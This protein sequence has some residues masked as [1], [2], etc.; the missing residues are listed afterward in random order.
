MRALVLTAHLD[1]SVPL[2]AQKDCTAAEKLVD[3]VNARREPR[4]LFQCVHVGED[5]MGIALLLHEP[6]DDDTRFLVAVAFHEEVPAALQRMT[7]E[8]P[9][10]SRAVGYDDMAAAEGLGGVLLEAVRH[11]EDDHLQRDRVLSPELRDRG[12]GEVGH[13]L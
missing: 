3:G 5:G 2:G 1:L 11:G 8:D 9:V 13:L 10:V 12:L 4:L 6:G 7:D